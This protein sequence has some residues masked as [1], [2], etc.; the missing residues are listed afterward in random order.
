MEIDSRNMKIVDAEPDIRKAAILTN[1]RMEDEFRKFVYKHFDGFKCFYHGNSLRRND[2]KELC[3]F[4][5]KYNIH[6]PLSKCKSCKIYMK[7]RPEKSH[8]DMTI[9]MFK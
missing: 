1:K 7:K 4:C 2:N 8:R 3:V 9:D 5:H 6:V